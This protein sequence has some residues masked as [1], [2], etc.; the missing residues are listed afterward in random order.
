MCIVCHKAL[1]DNDVLSFVNNAPT[2]KDF[3]E[4]NESSVHKLFLISIGYNGYLAQALARDHL[5]SFWN[6]LQFNENSNGLNITYMNKVI[7]F[8]NKT[9]LIF[10]EEG[11]TI[12]EIKERVNKGILPEGYPDVFILE[13]CEINKSDDICGS[14]HNNFIKILNNFGC[15]RL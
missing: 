3:L 9:I 7:D 15:I 12:Q 6:W 8:V 13:E 2:H 11:L 4:F 1:S 10:S 14:M 5:N